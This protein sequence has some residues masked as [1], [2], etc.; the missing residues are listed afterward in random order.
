M[1]AVEAEMRLKEAKAAEEA[2]EKEAEVRLCM[3]YIFIMSLPK[4]TNKQIPLQVLKTELEKVKAEAAEDAADFESQK[5][6]WSTRA[7]A[8]AQ[9]LTEK[10]EQALNAVKVE[11]VGVHSLNRHALIVESHN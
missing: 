11:Q 1:R 3:L 9:K 2:A 6:S 10:H 4:P 8:D 5:Q 7:A